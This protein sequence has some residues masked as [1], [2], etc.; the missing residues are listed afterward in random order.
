MDHLKPYEGNADL[1]NWLL[2]DSLHDDSSDFAE[3]HTADETMLSD[4]S[5][6][7]MTDVT[8]EIGEMSRD[9]S[10]NASIEVPLVRTRTGRIVKPRERYSP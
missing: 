3:T 5:D 7:I 1:H 9:T 4:G 8:T 6:N 10:G 2:P